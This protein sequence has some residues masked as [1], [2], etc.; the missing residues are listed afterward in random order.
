EKRYRVRVES[1]VAPDVAASLG[2]LDLKRSK[3][4]GEVFEIVL[5]EGKNRQVRRLCARHGLRVVELTRIRLGPIQLGGL[6][7]G[8]VRPLTR[9]ESLALQKLVRSANPRGAVDL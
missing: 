2:A 3:A 6:K 4:G 5:R 1:H 8:A 9:T 7:P